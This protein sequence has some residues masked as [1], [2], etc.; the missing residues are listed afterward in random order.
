M[1]ALPVLLVLLPLA[2]ALLSAALS[3][4]SGRWRALPLALT[5]AAALALCLFPLGAPVWA[6]SW[7][8]LPGLPSA[9]LI[10]DA[11]PAQRAL[12]LTVLGV[13]LA[14]TVFS[15][16]YLEG[17]R[18]L[19][20]Y[21]GVLGAFVAAML[22]VV[23]S[24]N[25]LT[26]TLGW[27]GVGLCS[28]L[29]IGFWYARP[30]V[31]PAARLAILANRIGDAA[32]LAAL[33]LSLA[34]PSR[35][36][37]DLLSVLVLIAAM[38]KS[39]QGPL[40]LWLPPAMAGPTPVSALVHSATMVAAGVILLIKVQAWLTPAAL[41][42]AL[43][44]GVATSLFGA[45]A[46]LGQTDLKRVLA[47]STASQLGLLFAAI[48]LSNGE[49]AQLHLLTHAAFK[50]G[51]F[52]VAGS[53]I[54][55]VEHAAHGA[56]EH[57]DPQ[58]LR[59]MGGLGRRMP[60]TTAAFC[61]TAISLIGLPLTAGGYSKE[62]IFSHTDGGM[63]E[64]AALALLLLSSLLTAAYTCWLGLVVFAGPPRSAIIASVR[65]PSWLIVVPMLG[66]ALW[67]LA[68]AWLWVGA[69]VNV[70]VLLLATGAAALGI[71]RAAQSWPSLRSGEWATVGTPL[72][73]DADLLATFYRRT[74]I[75]P[76]RWL[77]VQLT[78]LDALVID[79]LVDALAWVVAEPI[80]RIADWLDRRA[81]DG[82]VSGAG[83]SVWGGGALTR[84]LQS[85]RV[86]SYL[87][88]S[89]LALVLLLLSYLLWR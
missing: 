33:A 9:E 59:M 66:L 81:V 82:A 50:A 57:I 4:R 69:Q 47:Y 3:I 21:F 45:V 85:G 64:S 56:G 48:G 29:L 7:L 46:A 6:V 40:V 39:A 31:G 1:I 12:V 14:V 8:S 27:E 25:L 30:V 16:G 68:G 13:S 22:V 11:D 70:V 42:V 20:R 83:A 18:G 19:A 77:A 15:A 26:L 79:S 65:E 89:L 53:V 55:A 28:F 80:A 35:V 51:L 23:L 76:T 60:L 63:A 72:R 71:L 2:G 43:W 62:L 38:A 74:L 36:S 84:R 52:L 5:L 17:E 49:G 78:K 58:D 75:Y 73:M 41:D 67:S 24:G 87:L 61:L 32:L 10:L 54:H 86:Q 88:L 34:A 37:A 44:V